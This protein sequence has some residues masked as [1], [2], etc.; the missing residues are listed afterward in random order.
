MVGGLGNDVISVD[1]S[2]DRVIESS[3]QG[4]DTVQSSITYTLGT[5][6]ENLTLVAGAGNINGTGNSG[7]NILTGNEGNNSLYGGSGN[8]SLVGNSGN[9]TLNGVTGNDTMVGGAGN[10]AYVVNAAGDVVTENGGGTDTVHSAITYA[11]GASI[12][13]LT[14]LGTSTLRGTGNELSNLLTGNSAGNT[15]L[16]GDGNDTLRGAGGNDVLNGGAG[17]DTFWRAASSD[18]RDTIQDFA[19]GPSGDKLDV[20]DVLSGYD[21][22]DNVS[23]FVQLTVSGGNTIVRIDAN[24]AVGGHS[25]TDAFVLTGVTGLTVN[26]MVADGNLVLQ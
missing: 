15:L 19:R 21:S 5:Y 12:E 9:D 11:I 18:G 4:I 6:V 22:S 24:G 13:N 1:V 16:G 26:Q 7:N 3:G 8:D 20:S 25:Y 17:S 23:D 10:D 2:T 14:L